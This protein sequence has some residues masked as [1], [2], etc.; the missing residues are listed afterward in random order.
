MS[1]KDLRPNV[2]VRGPLLPEPVQVIR[3]VPMGA[4]IKLVGRGLN[5]GLVH[6]PIALQ[7]WLAY[8]H[9]GQAA[10]MTEILVYQLE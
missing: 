5:S 7:P 6:Q 10:K 2:V 4:S 9:S 1:P 3:V 8:A